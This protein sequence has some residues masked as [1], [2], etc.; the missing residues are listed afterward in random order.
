MFA[1]RWLFRGFGTSA[2][3]RPVDAALA[4]IDTLVL[5]DE[6]H[7]A[8]PLRDLAAPLAECDIGDPSGVV[9]AGRARPVFV[10]LTA[11][12]DAD[13]AFTL[14]DEDAA[15]PVVR[16]RVHAAKPVHLRSATD[17]TMPAALAR[18][19]QD[20]L[21]GRD[22]ASA[23]VFVNTP[24][25]AREVFAQIDVAQRGS[26]DSATSPTSNCSPASCATGKPM[27]SV[28]GCWIRTMARP[29]GGTG[30]PGHGI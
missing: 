1:S 28:S 15:H 7:L 20:F 12:G 13:D 2:S 10:S 11:T 19:V 26:A 14:D 3:M 23:V 22:P 4:G 5:L 24:R 18:Q 29:P 8:R 9:P 6:A 25:R 30:R 27:S 17:K 16:R 21:A